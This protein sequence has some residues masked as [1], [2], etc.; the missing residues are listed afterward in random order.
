MHTHRAHPRSPRR[1]VAHAAFAHS[2]P[3]VHPRAVHARCTPTVCAQHPERARTRHL[4]RMH[5]GWACKQHERGQH[6]Q[7][8][9][10]VCTPTLCTLTVHTHSA[11]PQHTHTHTHGARSRAMHTHST[12]G[13]H[14]VHTSPPQ[15]LHAQTR[16]T[17]THTHTTC[18]SHAH[19]VL[20]RR[21]TTPTRSCTLTPLRP[22]CTALTLSTHGC[23]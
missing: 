21:C 17:H 20:T 18:T 5:A 16:C 9:P 11:H 7:C 15:P 14:R 22:A 19:A 10:A 3:R 4:Q 23:P 8:T 1:C 6:A 12:R 2:T 13:L